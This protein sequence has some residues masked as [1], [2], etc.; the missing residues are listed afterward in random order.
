MNYILCNRVLVSFLSQGNG[1]LAVLL[2]RNVVSQIHSTRPLPRGFWKDWTQTVAQEIG[3]GACLSNIRTTILNAIDECGPWPSSISIIP[4]LDLW[5]WLQE[6][7]TSK[8]EKKQEDTD[9]GINDFQGP[10]SKRF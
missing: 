7:V 3:E 10:K 6:S 4:E 9:Q 1:D 2:E 8:P 5:G